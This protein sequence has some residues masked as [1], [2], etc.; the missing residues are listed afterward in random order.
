MLDRLLAILTKWATGRSIIL[1]IVLFIVFNA[2]IVP[3]VY[4]KFET[5]DIQS[6]Y[7]PAK[8][9]DLIASY[10]D[11]GRHYYAL[12]ELTL[13]VVYPL[14]TALLFSFLT[15]FLY[16]RAFSEQ[17]PLQKL[18]LA[19]FA[20]MLF[21]YLENACV[22]TLLLSYPKQLTALAQ[23]SNI[24]TFTKY[25]LGFVELAL[26]CVGLFGLLFNKGFFKPKDR[27]AR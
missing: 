8:A 24:F 14:T 1:L 23:I 27:P 2:F 16:R 20:T 10:G 26:L 22:V 11:Q 7:T 21:D 25:I 4:P 9:Y 15:I 13:D 17:S 19:P 6:T 18:G 5:L 12:I 3:V